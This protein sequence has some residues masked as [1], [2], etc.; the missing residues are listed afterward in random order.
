MV[1][2]SM[3][4]AQHSQQAEHS[5]LERCPGCETCLKSR[6][7]GCT[8]SSTMLWLDSRWYLHYMLACFKADAH[9]Y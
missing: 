8:V 7:R 4:V 2:S 9:A 6:V 5:S 1:M 3:L